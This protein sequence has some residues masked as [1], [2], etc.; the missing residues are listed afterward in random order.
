[1]SSKGSKEEGRIKE[2]GR[3]RLCA[4]GVG[5]LSDWARATIRASA[6]TARDALLLPTLCALLL[7]Q[8]YPSA[9]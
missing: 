1:M 9:F 4:T 6:T 8:P 3:M 2:E 7:A 5:A